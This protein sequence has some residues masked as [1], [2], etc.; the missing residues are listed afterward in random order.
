MKMKLK[1][2]VTSFIFILVFN[3]TETKDVQ[4]QNNILLGAESSIPDIGY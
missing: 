3:L 4:G 1:L 2:V